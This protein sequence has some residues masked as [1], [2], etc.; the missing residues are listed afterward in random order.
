MRKTK[1]KRK[2]NLKSQKAITLIALVITI[3]VLLILAAVSIATL[4]GKNGI[5][6]RANDAKTETEK[7]TWEEKID[8]A[9]LNVIAEKREPTMDDIIAELKKQDIIDNESQ[10]NTETGD[11]AT[12]EPT[13][14]ISGKLDEY[15]SNVK[16]TISKTPETEP[17]GG[18]ILKVEKVEGIEGIDLNSIE[19]ITMDETSKK[20]LIKILCLY[21]SNNIWGDNY[22]SFEEILQ[23]EFGGIEEECW[24]VIEN[25]FGSLDDYISYLIDEIKSA[26][27][28]EQ[29]RR[30]YIV[31][32]PNG[33]NLD[34]YVVFE[35][36][37]YN[38]EVV[39]LNTGKTYK[40][41]V[42][43]TNISTD[44]EYTVG[45][46]GTEIRDQIVLVDKNESPTTFE[47]AYIFING[48][49]IDITS[50]IY[51]DSGYNFVGGKNLLVF[52]SNLGKLPNNGLTH[53]FEIVKDGKS[54]V[55]EAKL[56]WP[57]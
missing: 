45:N 22:N 37:T 26:G 51:E 16:I 14:I 31:T 27:L 52:L 35:N 57:D 4:T 56:A 32:N 17:A 47:E 36:E 7:A 46:Y 20:E 41:A 34:E 13:Y 19:T 2:E 48:K 23:S 55:G 40:K 8:L 1:V 18:V 6:T 12:N 10:V 38:F 9:K 43:V 15:I 49:K 44:A 21:C 53:T 25:N 30:G 28:E 3:I 24:N 54:Y 11:I 29:I 42:E 39:D 5:L 50:C 33:E